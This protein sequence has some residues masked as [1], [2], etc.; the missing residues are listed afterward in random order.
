MK[1]FIHPRIHTYAATLIALC[2]ALSMTCSAQSKPVNKEDGKKDNSEAAW[3]LQAQSVSEEVGL[4]KD[5]TAKL[6]AAYLAAKKSHRQALK[7]LPK[8]T[9]KDKSRAATL[10]AIEK[11][12]TKF[13]ASLKGVLAD[14]LIVKVLPILGSFNAKW[15]GLVAALQDLKL[16]K[17]IL[18]SAMKCTINYV[19]EYEAASIESMKTVKHRP[20]SRTF[21]AKLDTD[22]S[23]V[24]SAEQ[25]KMWKDAT[26]S[27]DGQKKDS[28]SEKSAKSKK[29]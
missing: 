7:E 21:K 18:K 23:G 12:R 10:A 15:D 25:M 9:D 11:D 24:L 22:L 6:T 26:G 27:S 14:E 20:N 28:T 5:Q 17:A 16:E 19:T 2:F 3:K 29:Q 8:E 4:S 13:A 1:R